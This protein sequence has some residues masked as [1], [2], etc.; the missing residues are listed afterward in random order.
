M[1]VGEYR[2]PCCVGRLVSRSIGFSLFSVALSQ[3][4]KLLCHVC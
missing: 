3:S 2:A 1:R 4:V